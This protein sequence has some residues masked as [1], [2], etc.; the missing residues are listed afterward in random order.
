MIAVLVS[1]GACAT[2]Q[3]ASLPLPAP[4]PPARV[5]TPAPAPRPDAQGVRA[6][7]G[8]PDFVR[9]EADSQLWRYDG[10]GCTLFLFLYRDNESYRLRDAQTLPPAKDGTAD[11]ACLE[12]IKTRGAPCAG[13]F[14]RARSCARSDTDRRPGI[15]SIWVCAQRRCSVRAGSANDG[16][17]A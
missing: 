3:S 14:A 13:W 7:Y 16:R 5:G 9:K 2:P 10:K 17:G 4:P 12:S 8:A 6:V 15:R 1:L 11:P